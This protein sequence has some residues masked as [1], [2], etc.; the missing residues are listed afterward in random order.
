MGSTWS[1]VPFTGSAEMAAKRITPAASILAY[2]DILR[3][4]CYRDMSMLPVVWRNLARCRDPATQEGC[5]RWPNFSDTALLSNLSSDV[6]LPLRQ[7]QSVVWPS[8]TLVFECVA[9]RHPRHG[10][11]RGLQAEAIQCMRSQLRVY[12]HVSSDSPNV[13]QEV[14]PSP[15]RTASTTA[16]ACSPPATYAFEPHTP[17]AKAA[18]MPRPLRELK[19]L[20][21]FR[22]QEKYQTCT[23]RTSWPRE[24]V[25]TTRTTLDQQ[26]KLARANLCVWNQT[27]DKPGSNKTAASA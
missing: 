21:H 13:P 4:I 10:R 24:D 23:Q 20:H 27:L 15:L 12:I 19:Q 14:P 16:H 22:P 1:F 18:S 8:E 11:R 2:S 6:Y 25:R 17:R 26:S 7:Q 9:P 3:D 5:K